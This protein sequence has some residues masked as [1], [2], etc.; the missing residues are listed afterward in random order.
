MADSQ[1]SLSFANG[2]TEGQDVKGLYTLTFSSTG[3]GTITSM[4]IEISSDGTSWSPVAN[5]TSTP[6]LKHV[7]TTDY[8][9]GS[10]IF[11]VRAW[12]STAVN[13]TSWFSSGEFNIV[14][15]VPIITSFTLE[16]KLSSI[17]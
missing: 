14:N 7:D 10:W 11:R 12:D 3:T 2:P 1:L 6:W 13:F 15:Q 9:N 8:S 17:S 16:E 4:E 5:L